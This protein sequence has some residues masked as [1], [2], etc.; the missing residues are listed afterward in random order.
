MRLVVAYNSKV[1]GPPLW[2][3]SCWRCKYISFVKIAYLDHFLLT[4]SSMQHH[5]LQSKGRRVVRVSG[6]AVLLAAAAVAG[7]HVR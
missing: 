2:S 7:T 1:Y 3:N 4:F 6:A 5:F